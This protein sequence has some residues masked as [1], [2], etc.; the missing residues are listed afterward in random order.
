MENKEMYHYTQERLKDDLSDLT[1]DSKGVVYKNYQVDESKLV[2]K[3]EYKMLS[4][5]ELEK[6]HFMHQFRQ[7]QFLVTRL[8]EDVK[9]LKQEVKDLKNEKH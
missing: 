8:Q 6:K 2:K 7:L 1:V 5:R 4:K 3:K 9:K